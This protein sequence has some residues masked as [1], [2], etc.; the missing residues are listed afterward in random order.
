M[1]F[2]CS[3]SKEELATNWINDYF[4]KGLSLLQYLID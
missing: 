3:F 1:E 2:L 4:L